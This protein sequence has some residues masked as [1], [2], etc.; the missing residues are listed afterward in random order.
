MNKETG[1]RWERIISKQSDIPMAWTV[2]DYDWADE[3]LHTQ[4][5]PQAMLGGRN[6]NGRAYYWGNLDTD[7]E[8]ITSLLH[9]GTIV[10]SNTT[11]AGDR[12]PFPIEV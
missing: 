9:A 7:K 12:L 6:V 5:C 3:V 1:K 2:Q 4:N 10:E 11:A 8:K